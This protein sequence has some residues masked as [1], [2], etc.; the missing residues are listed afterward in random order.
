MI[1][2]LIVNTNYVK[3]TDYQS[4]R[5]GSGIIT[6]KLIPETNKYYYELKINYRYD[7]ED[8]FIIEGCPM[9]SM[10]GIEKNKLSCKI[11]NQYLEVMKQ[12]T[13]D[14]AKLIFSKRT[15]M[16][17]PN[18]TVDQVP[19]NHNELNIPLQ[20]G[21]LNQTI[22]TDI[23]GTIIPWHE[24][25]DTYMRI[26][27]YIQI[28]H[29]NIGSFVSL[30]ITLV[31][32]TVLYFGPWIKQSGALIPKNPKYQL[33]Y[34]GLLKSNYICYEDYNN[35]LLCALQPESRDYP[36]RYYQ[37]LLCY[38]YG[39]DANKRLNDLLIE[40][41]ECITT[42]SIFKGYLDITIPNTGFIR[43][44]YQGCIHILYQM[45]NTVKMHQFNVEDPET[46]GF[47]VSYGVPILVKLPQNKVF[48]DTQGH[49]VSH[50]RLQK[51]TIIPLF[52]IRGLHIRE[53]VATFKITLESAIVT[54]YIQN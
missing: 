25:C 12:Y 47:P 32:A 44:L 33:V 30:N 21:F 19:I 52:H 51:A 36:V 26:I 17:R 43:E 8:D 37:I 23:S 14:I 45:K 9:D 22:F 11:D 38:N 42:F 54:S 6:R 31:K 41:P 18:F 10:C 5:L 46:T 13:N 40:G 50:D 27:P 29:V 34:N 24:L 2:P 15:Q 3:Y 49:L 20:Q 35:N 48:V 28:R 7:Y 16:N 4:D 53:A 1:H 39:S